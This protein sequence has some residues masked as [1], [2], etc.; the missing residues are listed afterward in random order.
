[1][2]GC[3][4]VG[5]YTSGGVATKGSGKWNEMRR[6]DDLA[7]FVDGVRDG[8]SK[9]GWRMDTLRLVPSSVA[10]QLRIE[11]TASGLAPTNNAASVGYDNSLSYLSFKTASLFSGAQGAVN[12]SARLDSLAATEMM[13]FINIAIKGSPYVGRRGFFEEYDFFGDD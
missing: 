11:Y 5:T 10:R 7:D 12:E 9:F 3:I 8:V 2:N 4:A 1:M 13:R 6:V